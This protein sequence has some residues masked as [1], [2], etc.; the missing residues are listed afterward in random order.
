MK[1]KLDNF[2]KI[3]ESGSSIRTEVTAGL[4]TFFAMAYIAIV[5]PK[6]MSGAA[7]GKLYNAIFIATALSAFIG[8]LLYALLAKLP[9]AQASGM[10]LNAFFFVSFILPA[11]LSNGNAIQAYQ[12][13]LAVILLS[14]IVF[15]I[16]S[17][18]GARKAIVKSMPN[19][20]KKSIPAGIGLFIAFIG[21]Q[22]SGL[23][24]ANKFT[25][26]QLKDFSVFMPGYRDPFGKLVEGAQNKWYSI[27]SMLVVF[28]SL[29]IIAVLSRKNIKGAIII[30]ILTGTALYYLFNI[31]NTALFD[32]LNAS[33][34]SVGQSFKD[35]GEIG[36]FRAFVG[37]KYLFV[38]PSGKVTFG[39]I[40]SVIM[41]VI[42]F[43]LVDMFDT[44]GTL[45][46][47]ASEANMLDENGD[48]IRLE[49]ALLCDSTA[50]LAGSLFG[51]ST[52]TTFVE[53]SAGVAAGGRTGLTSVVT[54][55]CFIPV[56][57]FA[58]L[59]IYIPT[60]ATSAALIYVGVLM[61]KNFK[62]VDMADPINAIPAF[63]VLIGMP[64]TYSISNGIAMGMIS[65][66]ILRVITV[67]F[68][69]TDIIVA[70]I[71]LL[72]ILR[73]FLVRV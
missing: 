54:A 43:T 38:S 21:L 57:F 28:I 60:A 72:F 8:T 63:L 27:V 13:G 3:K 25:L 15:M 32:G 66:T 17:A 30:G 55:L 10:G 47:T 4:T 62:E 18:T 71:S 33:K 65:Y 40:M 29:I 50:T 44:L 35:F 16:L 64:L 34:T 45:V 37:F 70:V 24:G 49:K 42:T 36:I 5:N 31:G 23:I 67:R 56:M 1:N 22:G 53:S 58:P 68:K 48:P 2:F 46:G 14:G 11:F 6:V 26:V 69:K 39:V 61:L 20:L 52:V 73:F 12:K 41:L 9:F 19:V 7:S 51:T 59:A